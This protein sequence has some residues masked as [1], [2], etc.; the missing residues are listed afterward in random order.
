MQH[1][2]ETETE[3]DLGLHLTLALPLR[4]LQRP[5]SPGL[6][7]QSGENLDNHEMHVDRLGLGLQALRGT[8][9]LKYPTKQARRPE[10]RRVCVAGLWPAD[11]S[12][13][14]SSAVAVSLGLIW[15][16]KKKKKPKA[17]HLHSIREIRL[18]QNTKAFELHGKFP[19]FEERAFSII[20]T[21]D[22]GKYKMLNLVAPSKETCAI[23]V[24]GLHMLLANMSVVIDTPVMTIPASLMP[25]SVNTWLQKLWNDADVNNH[26]CLG[27]DSVTQLMS[28]IAKHSFLRFEDFER[29]YRT[30]RFRP[31]IGELFS[32]I[33][34]SDPSGLTFDEFEDFMINMQKNS[35]T[36][37]RCREIYTKYLPPPPPLSSTVTSQSSLAMTN[38]TQLMGM[39]HFSTFLLSANNSVFRKQNANLVYQDM[40]QPITNYYINSSHNTY[41]LGDQFAGESSVEVDCFD[42]I[43]GPDVVEAISRYAFVASEYP[44][45]LSLE[46]HCGI[47]QQAVMAKLLIQSLGEA[48]VTLPIN[49]THTLPSPADLIRKILIKGKIKP[50]NLDFAKI[51]SC[52]DDDE[53]DEDLATFFDPTHSSSIEDIPV[54]A[55][56]GTNNSFLQR[57]SS[58]LAV[59]PPNS[60]GENNGLRRINS[61]MKIG[62]RSD[63]VVKNRYVVEKSLTD[64]VVYCKAVKFNGFET[65]A[66]N[67]LHFNRTTTVR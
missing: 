31:E 41:L 26:G 34:K 51:V 15:D 37:A 46:T 63:K 20:Y 58:A 42:G 5:P 33:A 30:L 1:N 12:Q 29:L 48:L 18:G 28:R 47:E 53:S 45:I 13:S 16:S 43:N 25:G 49:N 8:L 57:V 60:N 66:T 9:M 52:F 32:S 54:S 2:S 6:V 23:W 62:P 27:L 61:K 24:S 36:R 21:A 59:S 3:T 10:E 65:L 7:P 14:Q 38:I 4:G 39:D 55:E 11:A 40:T 44:V 50:K 19:D 64:L 56:R 67:Q 35:M 17:A 22:D